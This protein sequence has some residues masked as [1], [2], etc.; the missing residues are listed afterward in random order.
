MKNTAIVGLAA[1]VIGV[2]VGTHLPQGVVSQPVSITTFK[3][4][5]PFDQW[6]TGFDSKDTDKLHKANNIKPIFRGVSIDDPR[7]VVVIHQSKP[8]VV[9]K[10]LVDN[11]E[12]IESSGHILRTTKT[13]NWLHQ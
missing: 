10:L 8:G 13:S 2:L 7:Q 4:K 6:A 5:V 11:K 9:E 3:I 12:M 1:T